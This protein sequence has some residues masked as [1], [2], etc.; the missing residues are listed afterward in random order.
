M[1]TVRLC[2]RLSWHNIARMATGRDWKATIRCPGGN[3]PRMN[4]LLYVD[5]KGS[6]TAQFYTN[7]NHVTTRSDP[8]PAWRSTITSTRTVCLVPYFI[9][10]CPVRRMRS[11]HSVDMISMLVRL[12][13][14]PVSL[15]DMTVHM[16]WVLISSVRCTWKLVFLN[17]KT[18]SGV[19]Q[20]V[21]YSW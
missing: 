11:I 12:G 21:L 1:G 15:T 14:Y 3:I 9:T 10:T 8:S 17:S 4:R 19:W 18:F 6:G 2:I 13:P 7:K 20:Y 5:T 16:F